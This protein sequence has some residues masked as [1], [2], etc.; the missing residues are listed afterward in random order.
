MIKFVFL[1]LDETI[2]DFHKAEAIA[3][4]KMLC[5]IGIEPTDEVIS[6]YSEI[7]D[8]QWKLLEL[9]RL[10]REEVLVRRF[11]LLFS[12]LGVVADSREA[13]RLYE[14]NL[15]E[16]HYFIDGAEDMLGALYGNYSLYLASN[17]TEH[18]QTRRIASSGIAKYFD[19]IFISQVIGHNKPSSQFFDA[20]FE[21]IK[22]FERDKA[23][24]VGDSLTSDIKGGINAGIRTCLFNPKGKAVL[25]DIK[26]DYEIR[27]L[28]ELAGLLKEI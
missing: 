19:G 8:A 11:D 21:K 14:Y 5:E 12:E 28:G 13:R 2:F 9:G 24:I 16:G 25:G 17:G 3:L 26:P 10:T 15:G 7:N 20:C 23:I 18:V 1:D 22:G 4:S 6:R 27:T